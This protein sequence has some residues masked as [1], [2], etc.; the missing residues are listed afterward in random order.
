MIK[1]I[2]RAD[3]QIILLNRQLAKKYNVSTD[4]LTE[5]LE[6]LDPENLLKLGELILEY[7]SF[8]DIELWITEQK[9]KKASAA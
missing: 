2:L 9:Q 7:D 4:G 8:D 5:K 3:G 6:E 1:Q